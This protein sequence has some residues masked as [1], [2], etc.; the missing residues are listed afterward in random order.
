MNWKT[1]FIAMNILPV[2]GCAQVQQRVPVKFRSNAGNLFVTKVGALVISTRAGEVAM[3]DSVNGYWHNCPPV[4][5][6]DLL[7]GVTIDQSDF[8]NRDTGFVSGFISNGGKYNIIYHTTNGGQSWQKVDFGLDGWVD[9]TSS[10][11][12]GEAWMSVS[13]KGMAYTKDFGHTWRALNV[14]DTKQRYGSIFFNNLHEGIIGAL[15]N[16]IAY[17]DDNC[18]HWKLIPT[19]LDQQ[20]YNKTD[21][22]RRPEISQVAIYKDYLLVNQESMVFYSKRDAINWVPLPDYIDFYT[23]AANDAI[24]FYSKSGKFVKADEHLAPVFTYDEKF[25][26][27][28]AFCRSGNLFL[29]NDGAISQLTSDNKIR[30]SPMLTDRIEEMEPEYFA[31][32]ENGILGVLGSMIY[33]KT[34]DSSKWKYVVTLPVE[35]NNS[36]NLSHLNAN[37]LVYRKNLDT[38]YYYDMETKSGNFTSIADILDDFGKKNITEISFSKGSQGCF[39]SDR[40]EAVYI[41]KGEDYVLVNKRKRRSE[42]SGQLK[43]DVTKISGAVVN[44]FADRVCYQ[45]KKQAVIGD[46][47]F[48]EKDYA[49]CKKD[50]LEFQSATKDK[51]DLSDRKVFYLGQNNIDYQ[52]LL[53]TVD[54]VRNIDS[55]SLNAIWPQ[56]SGLF[57]TTTN[58]I[59]VTL[60]ALDGSKIEVV[61]AVSDENAMYFPWT[62]SVN[63]ASVISVSPDITAFF[64][65]YCSSVMSEND[66]V[67]IM[68]ALVKQIYR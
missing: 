51:Y 12:N 18:E 39:H 5:G 49:Q 31:Y 36:N 7:S 32:D 64:R 35:I 3:A 17:T 11:D 25:Q 30:R 4:S 33:R 24:F 19:P 40:Q 44:R 53:A 13:G 46:M 56:I 54:S 10:L 47:K 23:D 26:Y 67:P 29:M 68:H 66:K 43:P 8:F 37:T 57:S 6:N 58:W 45:Y 28:D 15:W 63:G 21:K 60:T 38:V 2:L 20:R 42:Q 34:S 61:N 50:I 14:A 9:A 55:V 1:L 16:M 52:R 27:P 65:S 59:K 62:I 41:L 22:A 48:T